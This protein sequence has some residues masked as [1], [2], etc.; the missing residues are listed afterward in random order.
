M[1]SSVAILGST[2]SIGV[3][4]LSVLSKSRKYK[5]KLLTTNKNAKKI[6]KQASKFKVKNVIIT[7]K[8]SYFKYKPRFKK[9]KINLFYEI[10]KLKK[11]LKKKI[12]YTIN[13]ISGIDGLEP[14][15]KIIPHTKNILIANKESIICGWHIISSVFKKNKT[16]F[17]P[18]DLSIFPSGS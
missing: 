6:L 11:F 16:N 7:N 1:K 14:T 18:I 12:T 15:L 17:I 9:K 10:D 3:S 4:T 5:I 13:A 8:K 2:G